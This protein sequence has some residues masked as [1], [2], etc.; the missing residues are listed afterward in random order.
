MTETVGYIHSIDSLSA[1]DGPGLRTVVFMQGCYLKCPYCHNVDTRNLHSGKQYDVDKLHEK[2]KRSY[3]YIKSGGITFSGG[4]PL[5]QAKFLSKLAKALT[6]DG[7]DVAIDT[8]GMKIGE[9]IKELLENVSTVLLDIKS[10]FEDEYRDVFGI[11][12]K[13]V[14]EFLKYCNEMEKQ[15]WIRQVIV[16]GFNDSEE[17]I[18]KLCEILEP[19]KRVEKVEL[20]PFKKMCKTKW[21]EMGLEFEFDKYKETSEYTISKLNK[22]LIGRGFLI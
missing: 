12:M 10:V 13:N 15:I 7:V 16:E 3:S 2:L 19:F 17:R 6:K 22:V 11:D 8:A 5:I 18:I 9:D 14:L 4:E 21:K 20:L 1:V